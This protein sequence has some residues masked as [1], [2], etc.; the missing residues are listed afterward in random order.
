MANN[1]AWPAKKRQKTEI[2]NGEKITHVW[3][4]TITLEDALAKTQE[5]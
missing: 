1:G 4:E 5:K 3:H 2:I